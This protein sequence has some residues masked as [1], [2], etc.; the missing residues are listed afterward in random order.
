MNSI[1]FPFRNC[2]IKSNDAS[3]FLYPNPKDG[4]RLNHIFSMAT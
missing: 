1:R 3:S 2:K 4:E